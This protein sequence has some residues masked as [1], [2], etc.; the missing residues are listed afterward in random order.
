MAEII[1]CLKSNPYFSGMSPAELEA[2]GKLAFGKRYDREE[3]ILHEGGAA[4]ALYFVASGVVKIFKTSPDGK[5]QILDLAHSGESFN[6]VP[7]FDGGLNLASAQAMGPVLLCGI[8][9]SALESVL[10][11]YPQVALN[12]IK[13]MATRARQLVSLVEDLS[14]RHV[15]GRVARILLEHAEDEKNAEPR[16]TQRD[17]AAMAGTAREVVSRSIKVMEESGI[18]RIERHR[19]VIADKDALEKMIELSL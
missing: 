11:E 16:L 9:K 8:T 2:I 17:I 15:I 7:M 4:Q 6:D 1:H 18:I 13:V 12:I 14:F 5:E 10:V 19:I 3:I